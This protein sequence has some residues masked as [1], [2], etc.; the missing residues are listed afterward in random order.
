[1]EKKP[2][3]A[4]PDEPEILKKLQKLQKL[5]DK[6]LITA[7]DFKAK[8]ADFLATYSAA[9]PS[10]N[11]IVLGHRFSFLETLQKNHL[12]TKE[13]EK[14]HKAILFHQIDFEQVL[15]T[16]PEIDE[17]LLYLKS[18]FDDGVING[19]TYETHKAKLLMDL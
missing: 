3:P 1:V 11:G 17:K 12:I 13:E 15:K 7:D 19:E 9:Q 10:N 4:Q 14:E 8:K 5:H 18:I 16:M 2:D 6:K